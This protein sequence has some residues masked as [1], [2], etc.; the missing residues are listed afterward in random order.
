MWGVGRAPPSLSYSRVRRS[1]FFSS[2]LVDA[3]WCAVHA[4]LTTVSTAKV[5]PD[6]SGG[7]ETLV[8]TTSTVAAATSSVVRVAE[9]RV[10]PLLVYL[11]LGLPL[12]V[13]SALSGM[14]EAAIDGVLAFVG[15][16]GIVG[17][18]LWR[19]MLL[20]LTPPSE[21]PPALATV[22]ASRIH[23]YTLIQLAALAV[24]FSTADCER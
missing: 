9:N 10:T 7:D 12:L 2:A 6:G 5:L 18:A 16:E 20:L 3:S 4:L 14:P 22:R 23:T 24:V 11:L 21:L 8:A 17:T 1:S 13:P 15:L 19:R